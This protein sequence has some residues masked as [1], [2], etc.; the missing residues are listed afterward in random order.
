L[1]ATPPRLA[2]GTQPLGREGSPLSPDAVRRLGVA[3][4][5]A[6]AAACAFR[7]ETA[8]LVGLLA[9]VV[10]LPWAGPRFPLAVAGLL[11]VAVLGTALTRRAALP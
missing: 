5:A 4:L 10:D 1:G 9:L 3:V 8:C 11:V 2:I 7:F 6:L